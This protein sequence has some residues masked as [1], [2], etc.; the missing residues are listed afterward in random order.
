MIRKIVTT[1]GHNIIGGLTRVFHCNFYNAYL[2][3]AVLMIQ[4]TEK[5]APERLTIDSITNLVNLLKQYGYSTDDLVQEF[6]YCGFGK[7]QQLDANTWVTPRSHYGEV[8][9]MMHG[10]PQIN[11]YFTSGYLQGLLNKTVT[12]T[13]CKLLGAD[14]DKFSVGA[15]LPQIDNYLIYEFEL[16]TNIP[17]RFTIEQNFETNIDE[18][19]IVAALQEMSLHGD[20]KTGLIEAFGAVLT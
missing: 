6:S 20:E 13:E 7:L 9:C 10:K 11:C 8:L 1:G 4:G 16:E 5:H 18:N 17:E 14:V 15:E 12:E 19:K 3:M 2:Q